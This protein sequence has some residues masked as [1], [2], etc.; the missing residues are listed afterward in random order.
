MAQQQSREGEDTDTIVKQEE[1]GV[2][3]NN[4]EIGLTKTKH[5]QHKENKDKEERPELEATVKKLKSVRRQWQELKEEELSLAWQESLE[6]QQ[7]NT[8]SWVEDLDEWHKT[9]GAAED[10]LRKTVILAFFLV[11]I[12]TV[13]I[14]LFIVFIRDVA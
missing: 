2:S 5:V 1:A 8:R 4:P 10:P 3:Q 14:V 9:L 7:E 11:V 6:N 12:I 13:M